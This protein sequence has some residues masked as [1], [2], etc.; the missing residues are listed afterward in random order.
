M[1]RSKLALSTTLAAIGLTS[2][3]ALLSTAHADYPEQDIRLI[4]PYGPGG[5]TDIIFRLVSQE[6]EQHLGA[7]I[8]PVNMAGAG[9]T[10]GS[11]NVK[12]ATPDGYTLLGSHDTIALSK[13]AGTVDYS[14]DAFEPIAL[15]TQTI[16]IPTTYAGHPVESAADIADY[17]RENPGQVRFSMI[18]S[19]TDH[20]FWA[21]F[22][23]E[24][25]IDMADVRLVGYPDTGQQVSALM[26]EEVD[27]AMF[28]LPS[29]GAF[30]ED[31]TFKPLGIAHPERLDS[32]P[33]V[34]TLREQGIE[35]DHS[36]SRGIFAPKGTPQEV[37]DAVA[38]A[39]GQALE[40]EQVQSRIE[41]EFG[42]VV[43]FLAGEDYQA[44]LEENEAA[45][46]AAAENIDFQN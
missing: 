10:L 40:E 43:R 6:A 5:A 35:M 28:N 26:A 2:S 23:Q 22:F 45:L 7:S 29:G 25:G 21:Q 17:V 37:L 30:Y 39:Y 32:M 19:S 42:S 16:N 9:A 34:A 3:L 13:L 8:V 24:A 33:D 46:S 41:N 20:F 1:T 11:R 38:E 44:F 31:G 15:L 36:T 27:F 12:D 4:I 18:P 14:Y